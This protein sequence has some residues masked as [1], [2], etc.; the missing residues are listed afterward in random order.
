MKRENRSKKIIETTKKYCYN[1]IIK[2]KKREEMEKKRFQKIYVEIINTCNLKCSFCTPTCREQKMMS[3]EE[4]EQVISKIKSYTNIVALHV[5]GEPLMHPQLKEILK[6][7]EKCNIQVNITTNATLLLKNIDILKNSNSLRQLNLSIHSVT[8]NEELSYELQDYMNQIFRAVNILKQNNNPYISYR[9]WNLE[10]L[11]QNEENIEIIKM[12]ELEYKIENLIEKAKRNS[13]V[14]LSKNIF[15]NQDFEFIW[16]SLENEFISD[17]GKC[18]GLR[19]QIA[20]LSNGDVV[21][22][23][24]DQDANI[25]LGNIFCQDIEEIINSEYSKEIIKGFE[26]NKLIHNLCKRCGFINKF[27]I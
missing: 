23:C 22:C 7:C 10:S 21:P 18:W 4:F 17:K 6:C 13:F 2:R 12:L 3:I 26:N 14:E 1:A 15:L 24:L 8:K 19:N 20:I 16:P 5:K 27:K 25:K 11:I 9:L